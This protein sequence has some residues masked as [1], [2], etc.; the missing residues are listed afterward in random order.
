MIEY[1]DLVLEKVH[2]KERILE[3]YIYKYKLKIDPCFDWSAA[4]ARN[5]KLD[6]YID[7]FQP[8]FYQLSQANDAWDGMG[9]NWSYP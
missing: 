9:Y 2:M 1:L 8:S 4:Y 7:K 6:L 3:I 5:S